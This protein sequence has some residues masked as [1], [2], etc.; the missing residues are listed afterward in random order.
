MSNYMRKIEL[1]E[2]SS[3]ARLYA[4]MS[5]IDIGARYGVTA[6]AILNILRKKGVKIRKHTKP[7][8]NGGR[9]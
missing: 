3:I 7:P 5:A 1:K 4:F 2:H 6:Q 8:Q 9:K